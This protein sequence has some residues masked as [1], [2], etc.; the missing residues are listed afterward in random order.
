M[1]RGTAQNESRQSRNLAARM[2]RWSA[3]HWKTATFGWLGF[4]VV[5]F[6]LSSMVG[7]KNIDPNTTG[8]GQSGRM[9][10][11]L[12]EGFSFGRRCAVATGENEMAR[13]GLD[14]P[15]GQHFAEPAERTRDQV[16]SVRFNFELRCDRFAAPGDKRLREGDD[17][18]S[19]VLAASHESKCRIDVEGRESAERKWMQCAL[20]HEVGD[21]REHLARQRFVASKNRVHRDDVKRCVAT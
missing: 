15:I 20:F 14:Q 11:I 19:D 5:A 10:K 7:V 16:T 17:D 8:P 21:F 18:F 6:A 3:A 12:N 4:V 9:D 1:S 2:G 13:A